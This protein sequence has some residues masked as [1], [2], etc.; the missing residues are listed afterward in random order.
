MNDT[1]ILTALTLAISK[2]GLKELTGKNDGPF[3][4]EIMKLCGFDNQK[5]IKETGAG[6][7]YCA[8]F[9]SWVLVN[10]GVKCKPNAWAPS[11]FVDKTKL[12]KD[13]KYKLMDLVGINRPA[14]RNGHICFFIC[15][16][17]EEVIT[18]DGN[19]NNIFWINKRH[20]SEIGDVARWIE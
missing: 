4:D 8:A 11:W 5:Y 20:I 2:L 1:Q 14:M 17:G 10:A 7:A 12:V 9:V 19:W 6:Y 18:L 15:Q 3:I 16:N 13:G